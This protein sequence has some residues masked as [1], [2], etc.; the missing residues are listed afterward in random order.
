MTLPIGEIGASAVSGGAVVAFVMKMLPILMRKINGK[1][2]DNRNSVKPG[3]AK[4]CINRG[5]KIK[6][7]NGA[8]VGL[9]GSVERIDKQVET[10]RKENRE[11]FQRIFDK[12]DDLKSE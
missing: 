6:E 11:D 8:I 9:C 5:L 10:S 7:H 2:T 12:I 4:I 1:K 3:T